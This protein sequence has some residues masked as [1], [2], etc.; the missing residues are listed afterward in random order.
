MLFNS[1]QFIFGFL[2]AIFLIF[3][4]F[5]RLQQK[6]AAIG[7]LVLGSLIFYGWWKP[8]YLPFLIF[9]LIFNFI[10]AR[11]IAQQ[12]KQS[13]LLLTVGVVVNLG[14]IG[15][16]KYTDFGLEI[17]NDIFGSR[18]GLLKL[19]LPLGIS[20]FTFQ[21]VAYLVDAYRG[22]AREFRF[23]NY[24]LFVTFF[25]QLIAG[26]IVHYSHVMEQFEKPDTFHVNWNKFSVGLFI[27]TIGLFK[28]AVFAD[29]IAGFANP[30]FAAVDSGLSVTTLEAWGA[31]LAYTMQLYFDFS[32]YSDMA[33][34][35]GLLFGI[36]LPLNFRS[37]Y[38]AT[39]IIDFWRR[40]HMTLSQFLRDYVYIPLGGNRKG[41]VRR[42][43]NLMGT[44]LIGGL[45][46]GAGWNFIIWGG[47]HGLYLMINHA[48]RSVSTAIPKLLNPLRLRFI[49]VL[50]TFIAV[51]VAGVFFRSTTVGGAMTILSSMFSL[52]GV[53]LPAD[54]AKGLNL[55]GKS[56][57]IPTLEGIG[58]RFSDAA[59]HIAIQDWGF[60][61]IPLIALLLL[62]VWFTPN[63]YDMVQQFGFTQGADGQVIP[64]RLNSNQGA[65][66]AVCSGIIFFVAITTI[67]ASTPSEFLYF[68]F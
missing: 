63:A 48:Y 21:Q 36:Y 62:L 47:L 12:P 60:V 40:W 43:A 5:A 67:F 23:L 39:D 37:P 42:Y 2:P 44:M 50:V 58:L 45:W 9:S 53:T 49:S 17:I 41:S 61:G 46:H 68:N 19:L 65:F 35:L 18:L 33:I 34:G 51:V 1:A 59:G 32:G 54:V 38:K 56:N 4:L 15:Y 28:K 52:N 16:Y 24:C 31:A 25:P 26:P 64:E 10:V 13:K 29:S 8:E 20:F 22:M 27:F 30:V 57:M 55:L 66:I 11:A 6:R 7:I 3:F 14:L